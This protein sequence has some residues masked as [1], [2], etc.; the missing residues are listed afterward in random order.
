MCISIYQYSTTSIEMMLYHFNIV[1]CRLTGII[2][3]KMTAQ[4]S[5]KNNIRHLCINF[6]HSN[7]IKMRYNVVSSN[8][9]RLKQVLHI[10]TLNTL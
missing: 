6:M 1:I 7:N 4:K 9:L 2:L 8:K 10:D 5:Q 3:Q